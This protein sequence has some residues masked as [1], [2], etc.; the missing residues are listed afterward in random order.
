MKE[1][2]WYRYRETHSHDMTKY[3]V[4]CDTPSPLWFEGKCPWCYMEEV[5][6][7]EA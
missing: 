6:K 1:Q 3:C 2:Q 5:K 7:N 4:K